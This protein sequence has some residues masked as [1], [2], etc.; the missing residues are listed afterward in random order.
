[1]I[2]A[3]ASASPCLSESLSS[4]S[5]D[6]LLSVSPR[7]AAELRGRGYVLGW[8]RPVRYAGVVYVL[9]NAAFPSL[10]KIGY[11]DDVERRMRSLNRNSGL[12]DP[13]HCYA[14]YAVKERLEDLRLHALIDT[15]DPDLRHTGNREFYEME[16]EKA[17]GILSAVAQING[18]ERQLRINPLDDP[19]FG[20]LHAAGPATAAGD[21]APR[22]R[23][24]RL[25]FADLGI[26][27]GSVLSFVEDSSVTVEVVDGK[28]T[29]RMP[30]GDICKL[31]AAVRR[32][33][34]AAGTG[35]ACGAYQGGLY[36]AYE[37]ETLVSR[38][39]RL[40][41]AQTQQT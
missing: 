2:A 37:G 14:T 28:S 16:P 11:A 25:S 30:D 12:P 34:D 6:E 35:N 10:V 38:R 7:L 41:A 5:D 3:S 22:R 29:V 1:M 17:F 33:K 20:E 39:K 21:S 24:S 32:I 23:R 26:A 8:H 36:F 18:D 19:F 13:Y 27:P 4:L 40:E 15:L 9:V 31:S